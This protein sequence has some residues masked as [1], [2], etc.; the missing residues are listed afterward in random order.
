VAAIVSEADLIRLLNED[1]EKLRGEVAASHEESRTL[2]IQLTE[3]QREVAELRA[4]IEAALVYLNTKLHQC[5]VGTYE[6]SIEGLIR[7]DMLRI[8]RGE[9]TRVAAG[10]RIATALEALVPAV[11]AIW[12]ELHRKENRR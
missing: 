9:P 12:G 7:I 5:S 10:E 2:A 6:E 3:R 8:L 11:T 1:R 4:R